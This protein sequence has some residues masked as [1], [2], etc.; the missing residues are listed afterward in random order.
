MARRIRKQ[1]YI[2]FD[3]DRFL[4]QRSRDLGV[5]QSEVVR[6]TLRDAER[7]A[8]ERTRMEALN[9]LLTYIREHRMSNTASTSPGWKFDREELY[10]ERMNQIIR[11]SSATDSVGS[12][13]VD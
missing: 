9:D 4:V 1:I 3:T 8:E 10:E 13:N 7:A 6:Q 12:S 11:R 2:H 5:S